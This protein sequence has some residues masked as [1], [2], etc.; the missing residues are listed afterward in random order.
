MICPELSP[1]W[2]RLALA[3]KS[4]AAGRQAFRS[5]VP[6]D[7]NLALIRIYKVPKKWVVGLGNMRL[8]ANQCD[9]L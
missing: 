6:E 3:L 1:G 9:M 4:G 5:W 7:L 2:L 8:P